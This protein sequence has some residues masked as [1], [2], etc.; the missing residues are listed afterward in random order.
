MEEKEVC[1][2]S[3]ELLVAQTSYLLLIR[4]SKTPTV[5]ASSRLCPMQ[6]RELQVESAGEEREGHVWSRE[7]S[8]VWL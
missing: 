1:S 4:G 7:R 8:S 3:F 6:A 2:G 5:I